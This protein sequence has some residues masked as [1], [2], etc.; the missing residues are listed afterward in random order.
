MIRY[1]THMLL[2]A[3]LLC[4][5]SGNT[6]AQFQGAERPKLVVVQPLSFEYETTLIEAVGTAQAVRSVDLFPSVAEEVVAVKFAS[7]Q[8]VLQN[9]VL[10]EL[11]SR[12]QDVEIR[13]ARIQLNDAKRIFEQVTRS[14]EK[15]AATQNEVDNAETQL[16]L[17]EV[18]LQQAEEN[19]EDRVIRAPFDGVV[20]LTDI[21]VGDRVTEQTL[22][23]TLDDRSSLLV[24][25]AAPELAVNY[26]LS[27]PDVQLQ[28]WSNRE[29]QVTAKIAELDSRVNVTDR[30]L[31]VRA[32]M[33]NTDDAFRPGMSFRVTL[34]V[35]GER[36]VSIPEVALSWG[37]TGAYVWLAEG[38]QA[39]R[40]E[41]Q[42]EQRL[43]GRILI[44]GALRDSE[45]LIV[46]G[47]QGLRD[48]Q[49]IKIQ[50]ESAVAAV[51]EISASSDGQV[52]AI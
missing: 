42:V 24:N 50:N 21:E 34:A 46:E 25:F 8:Q 47:I 18:A 17:A 11:D 23:T 44:S 33:D 29:Q 43:R 15:G 1:L 4:I 39:K 6:H 27:M 45:V 3:F 52:G 2:S 28:P 51:E 36:Y 10:V 35:K 14:L 19:K 22:I 16:K 37:A 40:V 41:V 5:V 7:G 9:Q 20:G 30:T 31:R 38:Q 12:L 26:L 49:P 13:R 48:G 32:L